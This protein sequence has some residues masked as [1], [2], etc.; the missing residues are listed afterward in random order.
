M[1]LFFGLSITSAPYVLD[2]FL[3][4]FESDDTKTLW[5]FLLIW[6]AS[7]E[8]AIRGFPPI[9]NKFLSEKGVA[10]IPGFQGISKNGEVK[11]VNIFRKI[12]TNNKK[13]W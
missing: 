7:I 8:W 6:A 9:L 4:S 10:I 13:Y 12:V 11:A 5:I 2:I 1:G 3:I